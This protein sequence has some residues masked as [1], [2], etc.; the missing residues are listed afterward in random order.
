MKCLAEVGATILYSP[1]ARSSVVRERRIIKA[2]KPILINSHGPTIHAILTSFAI[3][4]ATLSTK[5]L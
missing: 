2:I 4:A 5:E 3:F 1:C